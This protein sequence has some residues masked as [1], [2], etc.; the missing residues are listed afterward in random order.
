MKKRYKLSQYLKFNLYI[1]IPYKSDVGDHDS[2]L[3]NHHKLILTCVVLLIS[4]G[5]KLSLCNIIK[6]LWQ[7]ALIVFTY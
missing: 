5:I 6:K 3:S 7:L 1:Y 2:V 4:F